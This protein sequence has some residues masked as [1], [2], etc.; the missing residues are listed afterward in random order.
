M[1]IACAAAL[2]GFVRQPDQLMSIVGSFFSGLLRDLSLDV[3][4]RFGM[5]FSWPSSL[6]TPNLV[7]LAI[8][9]VVIAAKYGWVVV[10]LVYNYVIGPRRGATRL[11][12]DPVT[13][14]SRVAEFTVFAVAR[15]I[16][17]GQQVLKLTRRVK[18]LIYGDKE[19][20]RGLELATIWIGLC[21]TLGRASS[22][23]ARIVEKPKQLHLDL[24]D[25]P[26]DDEI[27]HERNTFLHALG[28]EIDD[29]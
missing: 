19:G 17:I 26:N 24:R 5:S 16:A 9:L 13:Q 25:T 28:C 29:H 15:A 14:P 12:S 1:T 11:N 22:Y 10:V 8:S 20:A 3:R 4:F 23:A 27:L 21:T 18:Q 2:V 7:Q 6:S